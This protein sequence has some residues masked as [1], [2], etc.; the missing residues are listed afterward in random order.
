MR[1]IK[2]LVYRGEV[3]EVYPKLL[4]RRGRRGSKPLNYTRAFGP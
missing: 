3:G 4:E 2:V 1:A